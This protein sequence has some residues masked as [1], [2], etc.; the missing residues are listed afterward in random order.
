MALKA[1]PQPQSY[2]GLGGND[3][4]KPVSAGAPVKS[5]NKDIK[6]EWRDRSKKETNVLKGPSVK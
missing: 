5:G 1:K 3:K 4:Y 6:K 2:P